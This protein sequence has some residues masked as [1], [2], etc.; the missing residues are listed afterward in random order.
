MAELLEALGRRD[1]RSRRVHDLLRTMPARRFWSVCGAVFVV[2]TAITAAIVLG[3]VRQPWQGG[4]LAAFAFPG[5]TFLTLAAAYRED[6]KRFE[7]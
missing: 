6:S 2:L 4:L 1:T 7:S 3:P 5:V